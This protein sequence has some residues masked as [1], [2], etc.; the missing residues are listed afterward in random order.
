MQLDADILLINITSKYV[1][2]ELTQILPGV[3]GATLETWK[4]LKEEALYEL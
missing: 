3:A 1:A 2:S 4:T